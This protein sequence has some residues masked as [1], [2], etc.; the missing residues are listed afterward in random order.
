MLSQGYGLCGRLDVVCQEYVFNVEIV[1]EI[2]GL[3]LL[4]C[5]VCDG[6]GVML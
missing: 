6:F 3:V 2:D 5:V 1:V 4:M